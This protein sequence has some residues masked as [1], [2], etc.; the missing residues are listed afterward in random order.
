MKE[1]HSAEVT[2]PEHVSALAIVGRLLPKCQGWSNEEPGPLARVLHSTLIKHVS[3]NPVIGCEKSTEPAAEA[4]A[5]GK[6][7]VELVRE[8]GLLSDAEIARI[9]D[10]RAM[11]GMVLSRKGASWKGDPRTVPKALGRQQTPSKK[12]VT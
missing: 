7:I 6:G 9:L 1:W 12:R 3:N 5:T 2:A 4:M 10:P 11:T 8:K